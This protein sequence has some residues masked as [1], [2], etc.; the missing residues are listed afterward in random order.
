[1]LFELGKEQEENLRIRNLQFDTA[2]NNMSQGLCFFD[3]A[4]RLIVC[5]DRYVGMYDLPRDRVGP[6]ITL[7]EIVDMRFEAGSF[8]AMSREEYLHW[9]TNVAVS[10]EPTDSIVE[11]KNGRTFKIRHRPMPD[12]G[13]VATHEDITEQRQSEVKIEYMAHHDAL[14]GLA[15]RVLLNERLE[16]ALGRRIHR[17]EMV[18]VHH[19]D[20]DQF[21]AVNDT[22]GHPAG[23]K[24]LKIVADRLHG[25][26]RETD[27]VA[28]TGGDEFVVVQAPIRDPA[29]A[30][31]LAQHI[32]RLMSE[33][34]DLDGHQA[35]IGASIGIAVGPSDGL[36]PDKL[37]R[38]ADLALYRAKGDGRGTFRFF[39]PAMDLQMQTR[40]IMEQ[41]LRKALPAGEFELYYQPV[42]NL[43][44]ND[45][46]G[47]E[48]LIRWNHPEKGMVAP[49]IFIPLAEEI[50]FIVTIGEWVIR[51]ACAAAAKWPEDVHVAVNIPAVKLPSPA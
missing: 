16:Q 34:F 45:I 9:R 49:A 12:G 28:R 25:L 30:T 42:V 39:E 5:N 6:G 15:N 32:I 13:W 17:E 2:I 8:P 3:A 10:H 50:G 37:L 23:D 38:N 51:D 27:T 26:A 1:M 41:D 35:V 43:A 4:H 7:A 47:F 46:S 36:R 14:T 19:L 40:R 33:P 20:L 22:F 24:L 48:A 11:L 21:K 29:E 18:A 31:S 44:S